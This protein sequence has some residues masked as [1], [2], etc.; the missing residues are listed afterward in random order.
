MRSTTL[1]RV[2]SCI[3]LCVLLA[4]NDHQLLIKASSGT[5]ERFAGCEEIQPLAH[6]YLFAQ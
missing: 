2:C 1:T 4:L 5:P 3:S 6:F